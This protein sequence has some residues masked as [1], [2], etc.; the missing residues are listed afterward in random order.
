MQ[1]KLHQGKALYHFQ[2]KNTGHPLHNAYHIDHASTPARYRRAI[3]DELN[4]VP[5]HA[6]QYA[7]TDSVIKHERIKIEFAEQR[8]AG[9]WFTATPELTEFLETECS[10]FQF[11]VNR[12]AG[13][14][15]KVEWE[16]NAYG[17]P[18]PIERG[19]HDEY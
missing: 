12:P 1:K 9:C 13:Q 10:G 7:A 6:N 8:I 11:R 5:I 2:Y 4:K 16:W 18:V 15:K 3:N 17:E 14:R 19:V